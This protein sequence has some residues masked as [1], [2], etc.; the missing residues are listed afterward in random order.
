[1]QGQKHRMNGHTAALRGRQALPQQHLSLSCPTP[2][3]EGQHLYTT[4]K[5]NWY[6]WI[7]N[8]PLPLL[9]KGYP[10]SVPNFSKTLFQP[11]AKKEACLH[12]QTSGGSLF[13]FWKIHRNC[14]SVCECLDRNIQM[15]C[16]PPNKAAR[17]FGLNQ[18]CFFPLRGLQ[19]CW[20][21]AA[22]QVILK[23]WVERLFQSFKSGGRTGVSGCHTPLFSCLR[24]KSVEFLYCEQHPEVEIMFC[25]KKFAVSR[26][27]GPLTTKF[28]FFYHCFS[29][30][31]FD[32]FHVLGVLNIY[33]FNYLF[34][35]LPW[36]WWDTE[37][38]QIKC[39]REAP[40]MEAEDTAWLS[41]WGRRELYHN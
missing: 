22:E 37:K 38:A 1:M 18:L 16:P 30:G 6:S 36:I 31:D 20:S 7:A 23:L 32:L 25:N 29:S 33:I 15:R 41:R 24:T 26:L 40:Q 8:F 28:S 5:I 17:Q 3:A 14:Q 2:P 11:G 13:I 27:C 34:I 12:G 19:A 39:W 10:H 4:A 9:P 35:C 21:D